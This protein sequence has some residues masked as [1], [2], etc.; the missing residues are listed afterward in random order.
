ME[1]SVIIVSFNVSTLLR[2]C[3]RSVTKASNNIDCEIF[4]V[5]NNSIDDSCAIV[6]QEFPEVI[7]ICNNIN[8][9]FSVANNQAINNA[10]GK[11]VLL[12]NPDTLVEENTF[13]KCIN[14]MNQHPDAGALGVRMVNGNGEFLPESK[15][16]LPTLPTAFFKVFGFSSLFRG[17]RFFN[18]YHLPYIGSFE[19]SK[20]E[21]ISGAFMFIRREALDKTGLLDEDFFIYGEDIDLSY[22]LLQAG[23]NNYYFPGTQIIHF[24]GKSTARNNFNDIMHFYNAMRIYVRKRSEEGKI[25]FLYFLI[26]P[27]IYFRQSLAVINRFFR[28]I[29]LKY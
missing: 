17:S 16:S 21:V 28:I 12:L 11:F 4:V 27:A 18:R 14:F 7:L 2:Q 5:D 6:K 19:I 3:L 29:F 8:S 10:K 22:R 1:L 23:Y 25:K 24:K 26:A 9:G 15:R 13:T 20:I